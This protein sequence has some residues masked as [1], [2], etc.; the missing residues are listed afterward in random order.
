MLLLIM[1][2]TIQN[3]RLK[4]QHQICIQLLEVKRDDLL[5]KQKMLSTK[6]N[7]ALQFDAIYKEQTKRINIEIVFLQSLLINQLSTLEN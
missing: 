7:L 2:N 6:V 3:Y 1:W 5:K 4:E